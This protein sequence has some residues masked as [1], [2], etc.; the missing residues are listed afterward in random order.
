MS[1]TQ[2]LVQCEQVVDTVLV[3]I[4]A[5]SEQTTEL[6]TLIDEVNDIVLSEVIEPLQKNG[7]YNALCKLYERHGEEERLLEAWSKYNLFLLNCNCS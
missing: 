4:L 1:W 3:K 7:Q 5:E 2:T 6:Y